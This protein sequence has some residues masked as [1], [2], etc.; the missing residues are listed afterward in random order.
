[1][2]IWSLCTLLTPEAARAGLAVLLTTRFTMGLGEVNRVGIL[3][4]EFEFCLSEA[5]GDIRIT[6]QHDC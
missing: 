5:G 1:M 3:L 6:S 2:F 4:F